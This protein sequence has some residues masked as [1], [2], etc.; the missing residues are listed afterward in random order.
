MPQKP[1]GETMI[2]LLLCVI[3]LT[4]LLAARTRKMQTAT[5]YIG[6]MLVDEETRKV[7]S[8]GLQDAITPALQ[9]KKW[10]VQYFLYVVILILSLSISWKWVFISFFTFI[11]TVGVISAVISD[12][13]N[14][15]LKVI[16]LD[17]R[18]R[19]AAFELAGDIEKAAAALD[20]LDLLD[21]FARKNVHKNLRVS[22]LH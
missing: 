12:K 8:R 1:L 21:K 10:L 11:I 4:A 14:D 2:A 15:Y 19:Q 3:A 20:T 16:I 13:L 18:K 7:V 5:L 6:R 17:L 22:N 9:T